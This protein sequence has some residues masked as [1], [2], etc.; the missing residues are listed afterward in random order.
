MK[1]DYNCPYYKQ[2]RL[3]VLKRD[4]HT[5]RMPG[6]GSKQKLHVH[7]I[8]KWS[9]AHALRYDISNGITLCK[10]CHSS[11]S[12]KESHYESLFTTIINEEI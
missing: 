5:C 12:N 10:K 9:K 11:I 4:K 2:F 7:H 6:C 8:K 1:R 3:S